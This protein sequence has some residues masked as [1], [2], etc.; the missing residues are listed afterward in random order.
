MRKTLELIGL[1]AL[2][3][4]FWT[5]WSALHGANPLPDR[6][7]THFDL[8]GNPNGWGSPKGL[9]FF[10]FLGCVLY[11]ALS[12]VSQF[13]TTFHYPVRVT[14]NAVARLRKV[15]VDMVTWLK[16][17]MACLFASLQWAF[18]QAARTGDGRLFPKI[19]PFLIATIFITIGWHW[20]A[21]FRAARSDTDSPAA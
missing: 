12:L 2:V 21:M 16:V 20:I 18:I 10:P 17:E 13:P 6:V 3:F 19:L 8:A 14:P 11:L 7:A 9:I 15:T 1:L 5:A 4:L